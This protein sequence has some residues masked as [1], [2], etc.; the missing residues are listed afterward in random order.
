MRSWPRTTPEAHVQGLFLVVLPH[1][2]LP[3]P[4]SFPVPAMGSVWRPTSSSLFVGLHLLHPP[5]LSERLHAHAIDHHHHHHHPDVRSGSRR[6]SLISRRSMG[7]ALAGQARRR[8]HHRV[9]PVTRR[10]S[11]R[12]RSALIGLGVLLHQAQPQQSL[13]PPRESLANDT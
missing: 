3:L 7:S 9:A 10:P 13:G 12:S 11:P 2:Q 1:H 6:R 5:R 4:V 8:Q